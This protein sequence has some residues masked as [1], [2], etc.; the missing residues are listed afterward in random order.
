MRTTTRAM[1]A[2]CGLALAGC[3]ASE[4]VN[5]WKD[6]IYPREPLEN[7]LVIA[8]S[9]EEVWR[10]NW[11]D[12]ISE[13]LEANQVKS[14][15]SYS[16]F[17][18]AIPDTLQAVAAIRDHGF[19]GVVVSHRIEARDVQRYVPGYVTTVPTWGMDPYW[20]GY[21]HGYHNRYTTVYRPGYV[22][23]ETEVRY[24]IDVWTAEDGGRLAWTGVTRT[25]NPSSYDQIRDEVSSLLV[26]ELRIK[27]VVAGRGL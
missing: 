19:D 25:I 14:A 7:V 1:F 9:P 23:T 3:T 20:G 22:V 6:P 11:E 4:M 15:P 26:Q 27:E 13:E 8:V 17:P 5:M 16:L 18:D 24:Q 12:A 2:L 10:R 21:Y